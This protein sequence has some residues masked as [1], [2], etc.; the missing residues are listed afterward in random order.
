MP[1][2]PADSL[3]QLKTARE[4]GWYDRKSK[5]QSFE[6]PGRYRVAA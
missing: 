4:R 2:A 1:A 6:S 3:A 5:G